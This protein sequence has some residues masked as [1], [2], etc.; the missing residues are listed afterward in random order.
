ME[1][2]KRKNR[3][4]L[5]MHLDHFVLPVLTVFYICFAAIPAF[6]SGIFQNRL[7]WLLWLGILPVCV[8]TTDGIGARILEDLRE[9]CDLSENGCFFQNFS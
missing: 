4:K 5:A 3:A 9:S 7:Y 8:L 2:Q 6:L 1:K